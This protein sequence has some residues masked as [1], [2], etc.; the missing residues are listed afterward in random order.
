MWADTIKHWWREL[1]VD[2]WFWANN[3]W[4]GQAEEASNGWATEMAEFRAEHS[5]PQLKHFMIE[6]SPGTDP[7]D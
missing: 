3:A 6:L 4:E 5:Q 2:T 1:V 7:E